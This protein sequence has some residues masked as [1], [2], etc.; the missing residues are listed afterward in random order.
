MAATPN[1]VAQPA[2]PPVTATFRLVNAFVRALMAVA[3]VQ[4]VVD[5]LDMLPDRPSVIL[6]SNHL[7]YADPVLLAIVVH[8]AIGRRVR[9][10]AKAEAVAIPVFGTL[11]RDY[12]GFAVRRGRPDREA[13]RMANE[14]LAGGDWLGL[15]PEGTRS[16]TGILGEPK[17]GVA[18]LALRSAAEVVPVAVWGTDDLWPVGSLLPRPSKTVHI[19]FGAPY[20]VAPETSGP[21]SGRHAALDAATDDLMRRIAALL[22]QSYRGRFG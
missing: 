11:L 7:S 18:L 2:R 6:A 5:G 10:M 19:R 12:G 14:V 22:P 4:L 15:A 8:R 20:R 1:H 21:A 16:R 3:R 17:P 9:H 13:Y